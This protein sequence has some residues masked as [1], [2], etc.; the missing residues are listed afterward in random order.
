MTHTEE[1][2]RAAAVLVFKRG[3]TTFARADIKD[4]IGITS[5]EW[6]NGYTSLFQGMREDH[7]GGAP[8]VARRFRGLFR[9]VGP[10]TYAVT[11]YGRSLLKDFVD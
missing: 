11:K 8:K 9:R 5:H 3:K 10:G 4:Q 2:V 1:I 7:P 6:D